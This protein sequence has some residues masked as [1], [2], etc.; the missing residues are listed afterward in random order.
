M[1]LKI[2]NIPKVYWS[3]EK[4]LNLKPK[5]STFFFLCLGL[6]LFGLGEGL[7]IVSFA[8]ASPWSI[9]AQ[10][11]ALNVDLSIG[12]ITV[13]ISI[14]V[15]F[16]WLPLKQKPG[17][18]TILNAIIIGLMIDV[19]IKF[20]PTPENY[21]NQLILATIAVLTVG[22]GGG[23]YL[24]ANLGAG[25]R[26]GLMVGLQKKT[27]LPIATVRAFLEITV[28]SIGWYLGGTV[29]IGTLLFA[30]GIGPSVALGL[31]LVGKTFN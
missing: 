13:L 27:N 10:G 23:I 28:M 9:L 6:V 26:D 22:L 11:I 17:V 3:S 4:P 12:I 8:G 19:C 24:V 7:L 1:F 14:G 21:L 25:P 2:K 18:G 5:I 29:G 31:Y 30:F 16:L 20:I 15:L